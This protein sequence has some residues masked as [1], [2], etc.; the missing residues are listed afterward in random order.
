[1]RKREQRI[2]KVNCENAIMRIKLSYLNK[3]KITT[4]ILIFSI[5]NLSLL[6]KYCII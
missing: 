5:S 3:L 2:S 6:K 4:S 1:M